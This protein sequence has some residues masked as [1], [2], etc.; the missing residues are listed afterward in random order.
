MQYQ[1]AEKIGDTRIGFLDPSIINQSQ[2]DYPLT[3]KDDSKELQGGETK[4]E[5][6]A[7]RMDL[8]RKYKRKVA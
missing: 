8:H 6:E 4:D 2:H 5:R 7:I 3:L 1:V